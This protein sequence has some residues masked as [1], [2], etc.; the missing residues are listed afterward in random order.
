MDQSWLNKGVAVETGD[1]RNLLNSFSLGFNNPHIEH[2][3]AQSNKFKIMSRFR[4]SVALSFCMYVIYTAMMSLHEFPTLLAKWN[5]HV[6]VIVVYG[7]A[8][9]LACLKYVYQYPQPFVMAGSLIVTFNTFFSLFFSF[10]NTDQYWYAGVSL[11]MIWTIFMVNLRFLNAAC[12]IFLVLLG[13]N[14]LIHIHDVNIADVISTNFFLVGTIVICMFT[15]YELQKRA[16]EQ[17][18]Q[19]M[20][21][22]NNS[23]VLHKSV[24]EAS[25]DAVIIVDTEGRI[26]NVNASAETMFSCTQ[27][28][29]FGS[30]VDDVVVLTSAQGIFRYFASLAQ[31]FTLG[32]QYELELVRQDGKAFP[33]ELTINAITLIGHDLKIL[34]LRDVTERHRANKEIVRQRD[35]LLRN[36]RL[37]ALGSLLAGVA[38]ELNN[39]LSVVV[40]QS[41]LLKETQANTAATSRADKIIKA[42]NRCAKVVSTFLAMA[43]QQPLE[44]TSLSVN[45]LIKECVALLDDGFHK[46]AIHVN[47]LLDDGLPPIYANGDQLQQVMTN[48][49]VNAQQAMQGSPVRHLR[50]QTTLDPDQT[51]INIVVSDTGP[52][53]PAHLKDRIFEPFFTTKPLGVGNGLGLAVCHGIIESHGG[54]IEVS[55]EPSTGACFVIGLPVDVLGLASQKASN[56]MTIHEFKPK[57]ILVVDDEEDIRELI[58][59]VLVNAGH[60]VK[61]AE[62]GAEALALLASYT[63]DIIVSDINMPIM[64]GIEFFSSAKVLQPD[65]AERFIFVAGDLLTEKNAIFLRNKNIN[66]IEKPFQPKDLIMAINQFDQRGSL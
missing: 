12:V 47:L 44:R 63:P 65:Y 16:R 4:F 35:L 2:L 39:P 51:R 20:V 32:V 56:T 22:Q 21:T 62:N 18:Y 50:I 46:D 26:V 60:T 23:E 17:F 13:Y 15:N 59:E 48:V 11:C 64:D 49:M 61:S 6:I 27:E 1:D 7:F 42:A 28:Q 54:S 40:G 36:E 9:W 24:I 33:V 66:I 19:G 43:R 3:Y 31:G 14:F 58:S 37:S 45:N 5:I 25:A 57:A 30:L 29:V 34:Y 8:Y 41:Q 38:H 55:S 53:I 10:E 52:G